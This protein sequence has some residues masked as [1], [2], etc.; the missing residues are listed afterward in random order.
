MYCPFCG[1][2]NNYTQ[3][4]NCLELY[5]SN[6]C[7]SRCEQCDKP[8]CDECEFI[9]LVNFERQYFDEDLCEEC[10]KIIKK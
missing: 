4:S 6:C 7:I 10:A 9:Y 5:C 2:K 1:A 3:C 8:F